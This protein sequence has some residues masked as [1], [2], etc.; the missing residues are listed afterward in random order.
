MRPPI[1]GSLLDEL[2][3][4]VLDSVSKKRKDKEE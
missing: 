2:E 3:H 1:D 4:I